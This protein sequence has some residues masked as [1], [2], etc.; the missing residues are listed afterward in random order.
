MKPITF[1][2]ATILLSFI[3]V[4][5]KAFYLEIPSK[6]I[7]GLDY[8]NYTVLGLFFTVVIIAPIIET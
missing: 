6:E 5:P 8:S 3:A 2:A 4:I 7:G 1:I